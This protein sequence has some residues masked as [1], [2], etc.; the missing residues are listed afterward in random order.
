M[1]ATFC[2]WRIFL[3]GK[4][5]VIVSAALPH[6]SHSPDDYKNSSKKLWKLP[7]EQN[8]QTDSEMESISCIYPRKLATSLNVSVVLKF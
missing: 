8:K 5:I 1:S 4:L 3:Q 7:P 2:A 6:E